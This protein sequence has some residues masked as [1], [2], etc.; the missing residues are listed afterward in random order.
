VLLWL[1][2]SKNLK[3][4]FPLTLIC[5]LWI[6]NFNAR[7][8]LHLAVSNTASSLLHSPA[9]CT[10]ALGE[11]NAIMVLENTWKH[12]QYRGSQQANLKLSMYVGLTR[13]KLCRDVDNS[14]LQEK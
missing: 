11:V 2:I 4:L 12:V 7:I 6:M 10:R 5:L 9:L 8:F 1:N 13:P 14:T 3:I